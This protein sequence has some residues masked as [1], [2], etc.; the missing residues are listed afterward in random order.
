MNFAWE[1]KSRRTNF[2]VLG[3]FCDFSC[4]LC[5]FCCGLHSCIEC[6]VVTCYHYDI[7]LHCCF[8]LIWWNNQYIV[9]VCDDTHVYVAKPNKGFRGFSVNTARVSWES[10]HSCS[11]HNLLTALHAC[12]SLRTAWYDIVDIRACVR[13]FKFALSLPQLKVP[14]QCYCVMWQVH[15]VEK[16]TLSHNVIVPHPAC[17]R[18]CTMDCTLCSNGRA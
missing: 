5:W 14:E 13:G 10:L 8:S 6:C 17:S 2:K 12:K 9:C 11:M 4:R 18:I 1:I 3:L 15:V 16:V 7:W